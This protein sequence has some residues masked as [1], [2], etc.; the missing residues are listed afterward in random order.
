[1]VAIGRTPY[2]R[3]SEYA[4]DACGEVPR[5][6]GLRERLDYPYAVLWR[7][8]RSLQDQK[9]LLLGELHGARLQHY[10]SR[11]ARILIFLNRHSH[12]RSPR[13]QR[14]RRLPDGSIGVFRMGALQ[15]RSLAV[16][17]RARL[18]ECTNVPFR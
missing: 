18:S 10:N 1:L 4:R 12:Y 8:S 16:K 11:L 15:V 2:V 5:W 9:S 6:Q 3:H 13:W 17:P 14:M 7:R